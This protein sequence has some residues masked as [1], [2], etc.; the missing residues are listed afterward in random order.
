MR[1]SGS[2]S[3]AFEAAAAWRNCSIT[4]FGCSGPKR[5]NWSAAR[6]PR[7][8]TLGAFR[9]RRCRHR[10]RLCALFD[11]KR[12]VGAARGAPF[13][14]CAD[15]DR[16]HHRRTHGRGCGSPAPV[17][18]GPPRPVFFP[19][20]TGA[21]A[22]AQSLARRHVLRSA[23]PARK[24]RLKERPKPA[25]RRCRNTLPRKVECDGRQTQ[26]RAASKPA[27]KHPP[28]A[29]GG[30]GVWLIA[31]DG[32]R[33]LDGSGGAAVSCLGHQHPRVGRGHFQASVETGLCPYRLFSRRSRP[34]RWPTCWSAK[35]PAASAT[36][37]WSAGGS[38]A[39]E[40]SIK[41]ARQYFIES[42]QSQRQHFIAP[43]PELPRQYPGCAG[44]GRQRLAPRALCTPAVVRL[45]PCDARICLS[46]RARR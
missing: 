36:P 45:Q 19:S 17:R 41:L 13:R 7:I 46:R 43:P 37:I 33:I 1:R 31:E 8:S 5:C 4:S 23:A 12:A 29:V 35:S 6:V 42:G 40:A 30:D 15:R 14:R 44:R 3:P 16:R 24:R 9:G 20:L 11:P 22:I 38:E 26:P 10:H 34:R 32:R 25:S 21:I 39:I 2:G 18:G 28:I 27:R